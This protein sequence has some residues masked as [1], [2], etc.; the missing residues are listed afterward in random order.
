MVL[1]VDEVLVLDDVLVLDEV[2]VVDSAT[3][4]VV[5]ESTT[6]VVDTVSG[7]ALSLLHDDA[8]A[9]M[10][11]SAINET[12]R[13]RVMA[14]VCQPRAPSADQGVG[15]V[16]TLHQS[17]HA[18]DDIHHCDRAVVEASDQYAIVADR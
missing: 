18:V 9:P 15:L 7:L 10:P 17:H 6:D 3:D 16:A 12:R 1:V 4:E 13:R 5:V 14:K 2:L 11:T 8:A